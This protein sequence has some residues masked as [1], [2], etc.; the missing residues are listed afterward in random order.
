[1]ISASVKALIKKAA[2]YVGIELTRYAPE[3]CESAR[4]ARILSFHQIDLVLDVGANIGQYAKHLRDIGYKGEIISFEPLSNA[5]SSLL[6]ASK[7]DPL[8][9]IAPRTAIGDRDGVVMINN[10]SNSVSSSL[11]PML[12]SH[13]KYAPE[14]LYANSE[15]VAVHMLDSVAMGYVASAKSIYLK[16]DVQGFEKHVLDGA[17]TILQHIKAVQL[18]MSLLPLYE[19]ELLFRDMLDHMDRLG[20][21]LY[22]LVPGFTD[23]DTGRLVQV[24]GIFFRLQQS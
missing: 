13:L 12:D 4:L 16:I 24:D 11:L 8:W 17:S 15:S 5:Y 6:Q 19:D 22:A 23:R 10:A 14:S 21:E 20:Y 3:T 2:R 9:Q 1:M 18:E 7:N